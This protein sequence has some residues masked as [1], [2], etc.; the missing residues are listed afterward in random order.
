MGSPLTHAGFVQ[1]HRNGR[2]GSFCD[3]GWG[4]AQGHVVCRELGYRRA[5]YTTIGGLFEKQSD[6]PIW[7]EEAEC[8]G[9]ESSIFECDLT[10]TRGNPQEHLCDHT[11]N[12][13][14]ICESNKEPGLNGKLKVPYLKSFHLASTEKF[15]LAGSNLKQVRKRLS[16]PCPNV[17]AKETELH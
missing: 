7:V 3:R 12:A 11:H 1:I 2:W 15:Q 14:V 17:H 8:T 10:F 4:L 6:W 16:Q 13:G 9:N 5:L